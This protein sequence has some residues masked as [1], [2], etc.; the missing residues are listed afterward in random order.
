MSAHLPRNT[1]YA[2][3]DPLTAGIL[4]RRVASWLIDL[5]ILGVVLFIAHAVLVVVVVA[6]LGLG[7]PLLGLLAFLPIA[8]TA[9]FVSS[10]YEATPGQAL[11]GLRVVRAGDLG[12]PSL[13]HAIAYAAL[14]AV[15]W[16]A[17]GIWLAVALI[18]RH[19]R[20]LHDLAS[21]LVVVREQALTRTSGAWT[22][23]AA[24]VRGGAFTR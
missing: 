12:Q 5:L 18:T 14:F 21:G 20:A 23:P 7:T 17:G 19:H 22:M 4:P 15:T 2:E 6:T 13:L 3:P 1:V 16:A 11:L 9:L 24:T 10:R 8:Y